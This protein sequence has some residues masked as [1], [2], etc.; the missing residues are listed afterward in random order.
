MTNLKIYDHLF[1]RAEAS[2]I[3]WALLADTYNSRNVGV[4]NTAISHNVKA[5]ERASWTGNLLYNIEGL[6]DGLDKAGPFSATVGMLAGIVYDYCEVLPDYAGINIYRDGE[7]FV[8][9]HVDSEVFV[10]PQPGKAFVATISFGA[11]RDVVLRRF[12]SETD[13]P[14]AIPGNSLYVMAPTLQRTHTHAVPK[15]PECHE[16]RVSVTFFCAQQAKFTEI[17]WNL[18][19]VRDGAAVP[20]GTFP[21]KDAAIQWVN[22]TTE[23]ETAMLITPFGQKV[24]AYG[25]TAALKLYGIEPPEMPLPYA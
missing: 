4:T 15:R 13:D 2:K 24:D 20:I 16:G 6:T 19:A 12:D 9:P 22:L 23:G 25:I 21:P 8:G 5:I 10:G 18:I 3:Y 17:W 11:T 1:E 14:Y 7:D